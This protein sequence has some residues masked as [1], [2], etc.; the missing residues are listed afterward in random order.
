MEGKQLGQKHQELPNPVSK[1]PVIF[2]QRTRLRKKRIRRMI[3]AVFWHKDMRNKNNKT[4]S[5]R[6]YAYVEAGLWR[7]GFEPLFYFVGS[8]M[9]NVFSTQTSMSPSLSQFWNSEQP[10]N[11]RKSVP[12][13]TS[14][15]PPPMNYSI[16]WNGRESCKNVE[17]PPGFSVQKTSKRVLQSV[18]HSRG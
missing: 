3:H 5:K 8:H 16:P 12:T 13:V 4:I 17:I 6:F 9:T 11:P 10:H 14:E 15:V 2:P 1:C 18:R 7:W